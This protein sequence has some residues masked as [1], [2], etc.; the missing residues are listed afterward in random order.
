VAASPPE[1]AKLSSLPTSSS[2]D[3]DGRHNLHNCTLTNALGIVI[4]IIVA[5]ATLWSS[6][7]GHVRDLEQR[8]GNTSVAWPLPDGDPS[9]RP[10]HVT[11]QTAA[12]NE[13]TI[14]FAQLR[15]RTPQ[16]GRPRAEALS[17]T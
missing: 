2:C 7:W 6:A 14:F 10:A 13:A 4:D 9:R 3:K 17:D 15:F 11:L 1:G 16:P 5:L 8:A 12:T